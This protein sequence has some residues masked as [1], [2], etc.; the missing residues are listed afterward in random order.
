MAHLAVSILQHLQFWMDSFHIRHKWSLQWERVSH[1][2]TFDL[3]PYFQVHSATNCDKTA[4]IWHILL[5]PLYSMYSSGWI[6]PYLAQMITSMWGYVA[7]NDLWPWIISLRSFSHDFAIKLLKYG[8]SCHVGSTAHTVLDKLF[9]YLAQI[10]T[11]M[12]GCI[13]DLDQYLN[14]YLAVMPIYVI[15]RVR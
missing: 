13:F 14:G 15:A 8:T 10:I 5:C 3:D 2:T 6:L 11:S 1:A 9:S 7:C 4:K 12:R